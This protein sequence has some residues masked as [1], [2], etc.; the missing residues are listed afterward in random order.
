M[1][2]ECEKIDGNDINDPPA[3]VNTGVSK[4]RTHVDASCMYLQIQF[5]SNVAG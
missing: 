1:E 5:R 4:L 2:K 3:V